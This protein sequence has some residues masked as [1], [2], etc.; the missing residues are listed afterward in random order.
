MSQKVGTQSFSAIAAAKAGRMAKGRHGKAS[1]Y[2]KTS[3]EPAAPGNGM[4]KAPA[5]G[6]H[7]TG[8]LATGAP[9]A[10]PDL[11]SLLGG[12]ASWVKRVF[13]AK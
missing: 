9:A 2:A 12:I 3:Q 7:A 11:G 8:A 13:D 1:V 5:T 10:P 6:A 4:G